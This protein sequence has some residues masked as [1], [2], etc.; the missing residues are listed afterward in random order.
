MSVWIRFPPSWENRVIQ[1]VSSQL[2]WTF[3]NYFKFSS[4]TETGAKACANIDRCRK[5]LKLLLFLKDRKKFANEFNFPENKVLNWE[6]LKDTLGRNIHEPSDLHEIRFRT[7]SFPF[8]VGRELFWSFYCFFTV[9][10]SLDVNKAL[11]TRETQHFSKNKN[12]SGSIMSCC[13][14]DSQRNSLGTVRSTKCCLLLR[15]AMKTQWKLFII[16]FIY[17]LSEEKRTRCIYFCRTHFI[18]IAVVFHSILQIFN[19]QKKIHLKFIFN[20]R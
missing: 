9:G 5:L 14:V 18:Y 11:Q 6:Y 2:E 19:I 16:W 8:Q 3:S 17:C 4:N 13:V 10:C 20:L 12:F 15:K 7:N 1:L